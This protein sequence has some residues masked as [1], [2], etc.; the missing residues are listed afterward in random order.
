MSDPASATE[1]SGSASSWV[2]V[3]EHPFPPEPPTLPACAVIAL[4]APAP[5]PLTVLSDKGGSLGNAS[6]GGSSGTASVLSDNVSV[7]PMATSTSPKMQV[8]AHWGLALL[9]LKMTPVILILRVV[10][11]YLSSPA[12][13]PAS[14][15]RLFA[16]PEI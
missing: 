1:A 6:V 10:Q 7:C 5:G 15:I 2:A 11:V 4:E 13:T 9:T 14:L 12:L 16:H 8:L 3:A